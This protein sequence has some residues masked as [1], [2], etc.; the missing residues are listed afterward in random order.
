MCD[1][2]WFC[3]IWS[4]IKVQLDGNGNRVG[5]SNGNSVEVPS[6]DE[7][8]AEEEWEG[9]EQIEATISPLPSHNEEEVD[10]EIVQEEKNNRPY[11]EFTPLAKHRCKRV[12]KKQM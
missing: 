4:H 1:L 2:D 8:E 7:E 12:I 6:H 11:K 5:S 3:K 10:D 9:R